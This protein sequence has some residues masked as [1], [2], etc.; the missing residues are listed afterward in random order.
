MEWLE[1]ML[2]TSQKIIM[3]KSIILDLVSENIFFTQQCFIL[4]IT[5]PIILGGGFLDTHFTV[6]DVGDC[7]INLYGTITKH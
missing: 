7:T 6:L 1:V 3:K 4:P 5:N 2:L